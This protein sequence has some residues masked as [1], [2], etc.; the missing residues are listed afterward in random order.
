[1]INGRK[2]RDNNVE[3]GESRAGKATL[4]FWVILL[5]FATSGCHLTHMSLTGESSEVSSEIVMPDEADANSEVTAPIASEK[6][7]SA[8]RVQE[9]GPPADAEAES[10]RD[11]AR[12]LPRSRRL[13]QRHICGQF[14]PG[15]IQLRQ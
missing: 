15:L 14:K 11:G 8:T 3:R 2:H 5:S 9:S 10:L 1:M 7:K 4:S 6:A 13:I 12:H